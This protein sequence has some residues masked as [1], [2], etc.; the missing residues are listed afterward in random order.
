[1]FTVAM[2]APA[3]LDPLIKY[4][5]G[6]VIAVGIPLIPPVSESKVRPAGKAPLDN[7]QYKK[8]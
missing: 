8:Q 5:L 6:A 7:H 4:V 2:Y 1:M 3:G